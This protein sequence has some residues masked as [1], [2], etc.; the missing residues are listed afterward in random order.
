ME[1][2]E[3][4]L[5]LIFDL[6]GHWNALLLLDEADV[7]LEQ[8]SLHDVHRNALVSVFL[9]TL[10]YY[11]GIMFLTTN[12]LKHIDDAIASRIHLPVKYN[13]LSSKAKRD[14]WESFLGK[15]VTVKGGAS[16]SSKDIDYLVGKELNGRQVI[17]STNH[18]EDYYT[19]WSS[20]SDI[21]K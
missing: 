10:E 9:R 2:L 11:Q 4:Q 18:S 17:C 8:R 5:S 15:A 1:A 19:D 13:T 20:A 3:S 6:A 12:R 16:V 7:F 21:N 14:I